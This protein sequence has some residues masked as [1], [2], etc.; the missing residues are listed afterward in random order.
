[1]RKNVVLNVSLN[2]HTT[3]FYKYIHFIDFSGHRFQ[4]SQIILDLYSKKPQFQSYIHNRCIVD[5]I[6]PVE[7]D[8][9]HPDHSVQLQQADD[10]RHNP[11]SR[12]DLIGTSS[13]RVE[14]IIQPQFILHQAYGMDIF[15]NSESRYHGQ[16]NRFACSG[17]G[18]KN[19]NLVSQFNCIFF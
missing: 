12:M 17:F 11:F 10:N 7:T 9:W 18:S 15:I 4:N 16:K 19:A 13:N 2:V 3:I 6:C 1:M 5:G 8:S 14:Q